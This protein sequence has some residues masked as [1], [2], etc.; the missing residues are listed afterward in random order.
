VAGR[1]EGGRRAAARPGHRVQ[2]D[3]VR[4]LAVGVVLQV[5]LHRVALAHADE[6]AR[7]VPPKVQKV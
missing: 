7:H 1:G 4:H 6:A 5:E 3:V 2:V